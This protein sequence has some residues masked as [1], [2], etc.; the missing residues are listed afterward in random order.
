MKRVGIGLT[1]CLFGCD[2]EGGLNQNQQDVGNQ[3]DGVSIGDGDIAIDPA[4]EYFLSRA[5]TRLVKANIHD[6][7]AVLLKA[8]EDP[9]RVLF[10]QPGR[11]YV[12]VDSTKGDKLLAYDVK[13]QR[14]LWN[15]DIEIQSGPT[16][17][18]GVLYFP[19]LEVTDDN[20]HI[21]V[22]S[23][24][25]IEIVRA[26]DGGVVR[27]E[28]FSK[29]IVDVD[30]A[31]AGDEVIV[32]LDHKWNDDNP[33][34]KIVSVPMGPEGD[35]VTTDVPNCSSELA[36]APDGKYA[37]L[38]P[39]ECQKDPVSV[40][41]LENDRFV[42]NLPGFGPVALAPGGDM[43][44]AFLDTEAMDKSLF[45]DKSKIPSSGDQYHLMLIDT[46]T[47]DFDT[48]PVGDT[49]PRYALTRDGKMVLVDAPTWF[50]DG[51]IRILD[52]QEKVLTPVSGPDVRLDNWVISQDSTRLFLLD[53][54]LFDLSV[55][56]ATVTDVTLDFL[57]TNLNLTADDALLLLR[58]DS[59]RVW[60][61][62]TGAGAM[63]R[64]I[65]GPGKAPGE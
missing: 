42:R 9:D 29:I 43:M 23:P 33:K 3:D 8:I 35:T 19:L 57:P 47:L 30:V 46:A 40:I 17:N 10:G 58:E 41:D 44:V 55:P 21:V 49:L 24:R 13:A 50:D 34:T 54:G 15:H 7:E 20:E 32:T 28:T 48:V 62:D 25:S 6:D 12:T 14:T 16:D 45:D 26:K 5:G 39:T 38:A 53:G 60:V 36:V 18:H 11:I 37:F 61:Y 4:G 27:T 51:R 52:V 31:P 22:T 63:L 1:L 65:D 2:V 56:D 64:A 59:K